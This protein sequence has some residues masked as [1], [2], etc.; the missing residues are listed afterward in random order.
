MSNLNYVVV[1]G[2]LTKAAEL[3][4]FADGTPYCNFSI[5]CNETFKNQNGEYENI[6]SFLIVQ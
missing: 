3:S 1:E 4:H 6:P 2:H 5:A